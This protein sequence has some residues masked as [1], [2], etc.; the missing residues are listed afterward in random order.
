MFLSLHWSCFM[1][2][3]RS[4]SSRTAVAST[5]HRAKRLT[6][7][8]LMLTMNSVASGVSAFSFPPSPL[9]CFVAGALSPATAAQNGQGRCEN[10]FEHSPRSCHLLPVRSVKTMLALLLALAWAPLM[11]HC[12]LEIIPAFHWLACKSG[13]NSEPGTTSHCGAGCCAAETSSYPAPAGR[14]VR[15]GL[16]VLPPLVNALA[17]LAVAPPSEFL[18]RAS[19]DPPPEL[20]PT[21]QFAHRTAL[22]PRAPSHLA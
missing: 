7:Y 11:S 1:L 22:S 14:P 5:G 21:W 3:F 4:G 19:S 2:Q 20:L 8:C 13:G 17:R 15:L 9:N 16:H 6:I 18:L 12:A 10:A